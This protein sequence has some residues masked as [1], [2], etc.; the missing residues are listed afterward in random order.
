[1]AKEKR[2]TMKNQKGFTLIELL[3]VVAIIGII[4][5]IAIP[6]LLRARVSANEAAMIGDIRTVISA[7]AA[8]QGANGGWYAVNLTCLTTPSAGCIP[9]YSVNSPTF[10]DPQISG[11]TA[12][13]GYN[14]SFIPG[15]TAT[16]LPSTVD[17]ASTGQYAYGGTPSVQ[18]QT[19]VRGFAGDASGVICWTGDGTD[20]AGGNASLT[21]GCSPL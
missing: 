20:P 7:Q 2:R 12:K 9:N 3:I 10:L 4:A 11:A 16:G 13:Q 18:D 14:R 19:G 21:A 8:Y 6:S 1:M 17:P 5:A 15:A